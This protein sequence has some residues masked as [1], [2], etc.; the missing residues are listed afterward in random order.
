MLFRSSWPE[1]PRDSAAALLLVEA[2]AR[3]LR[4]GEDPSD[5][6][7][8]ARARWPEAPG[9]SAV[10]AAWLA[11][12]P[13]T[14]TPLPKKAPPPEQADVAGVHGVVVPGGLLVHHPVLGRRAVEPPDDRPLRRAALAERVAT[15]LA[16][17]TGADRLRVAWW[18]AHA[19]QLDVARAVLA[20]VPV[21][22]D[23]ALRSAVLRRLG[24]PAGP[25]SPE[26][27]GRIPVDESEATAQ[28]SSSRGYPGSAV[29]FPEASG[30]KLGPRTS[31]E[32]SSG[33]RRSRQI[34]RAHV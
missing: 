28:P 17:T 8:L 13:L 11:T 12:R 29:G 5:R 10:E 20:E 33:R 21:G 30:E 15:I 24:E 27:R 31:R 9:L 4:A 6:L 18:A 2:A 1:L 34:G 26:S 23:P 7:A 19:G 3:A 32:R 25:A 14:W 16:M 22:T